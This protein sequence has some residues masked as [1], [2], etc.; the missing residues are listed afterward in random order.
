[1][2]PF[3]VLIIG[4]G[5]SGVSCALVLGSAV[6]K[7]CAKDKKIG[8][9]THQKAASLQNGVYNN[10]YGIPAGKLGSA[11]LEESLEHLQN[12]YSH[13]AQIANEK[14]LK[15]NT[16]EKHFEVV[17]NKGTYTSKIVVIGIGASQPMTI[18]GLENYVIPHRKALAAKNRIQLENTDFLVNKGMYVIGTLAGTRSQL[19]IAAGTGAS[20]AG[21]IL[22][23]WNDGEHVQVH[24]ALGK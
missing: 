23:L 11:I 9:I 10:V 14:V 5:A 21:D 4:G 18:E 3:D 6:E 15:I 17:T 16:F 22:T 7:N 8:I 2:K 13:V 20:V 24:D 1:M 19:S 12:T